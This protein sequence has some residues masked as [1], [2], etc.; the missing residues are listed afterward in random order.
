M[1]LYEVKRRAPRQVMEDFT[2]T[3]KTKVTT[4]MD[5]E[6]Y[7]FEKPRKFEYEDPSPRIKKKKS[8]DSV[9][10]VYMDDM[11]DVKPRKA[12]RAVEEDFTP[13]R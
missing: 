10:D 6:P 1:N 13:T 2:P 7:Y 4:D 12:K 11:Q 8:L 5:A 9:D 3:R